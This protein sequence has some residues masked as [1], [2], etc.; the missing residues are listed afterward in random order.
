[1]ALDP[2]FEK[3]LGDFK[4]ALHLAIS[5][6][7]AVNRTWQRLRE[8]GYNLHLV[9]DCQRDAVLNS[10]EGETPRFQI[11]GEDL[12]FLRSVGIDPTLKPPRRNRRS[13]P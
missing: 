4:A 3:M 10:G 12:A 7:R 8:E 11:T 1:M 9:V 2:Q 6:S 5:G 13:A